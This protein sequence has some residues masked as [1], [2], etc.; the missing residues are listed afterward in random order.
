MTAQDIAEAEV[1]ARKRK[2][3]VENLQAF[4][5]RSAPSRRCKV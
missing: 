1:L 4:V 5:P 3:E 2:R